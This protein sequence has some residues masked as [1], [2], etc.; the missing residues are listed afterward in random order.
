MRIWHISD[1]HTHHGLLE[2]PKNIDCVIFSGDGSNSRD[3][4]KNEFEYRQFLMWIWK[5]PI[6]HKIVIAGNHESSVERGLVKV[7]DF[8]D[9]DITYLFNNSVTIDGI[10][11]WGSPHT[12]HFNNWFF[13]KDRGKIG[14]VWDSAPDDVDVFISHGP[15]K[16]VLD[17]SGTYSHDIEFCGDSAL[18]KRLLNI[19]PALV[20][21]GHIHNF[22]DHINAGTMRYSISDTVYS[23]GSVVTDNKFGKITSNGNIFEINEV[24]KEVKII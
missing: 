12:P 15:P 23:N 10:K 8:K 13:T 19:E 7:D 6:K 5:L 11:F 24:T 17:V 14:R 2:V 16:G 1:T 22:K 3:P 21:F 20:C 18:K 9:Y 4:F